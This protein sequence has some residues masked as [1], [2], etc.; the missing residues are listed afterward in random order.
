MGSKLFWVENIILIEKLKIL[1]LIDEVFF[2]DTRI[3][4]HTS[5]PRT[6]SSKANNRKPLLQC[7]CSCTA[8]SGVSF[9]DQEY[10]ST[11]T[12]VP[13]GVTD[14]A[15]LTTTTPMTP[16]THSSTTTVQH[17]VIPGIFI[18]HQPSS[19][20]G[21]ISQPSFRPA[22]WPRPVRTIFIKKIILDFKNFFIMI[23]LVTVSYFW[24][25]ISKFSNNFKITCWISCHFSLF[26]KK[27]YL[28]YKI[29]VFYL[30]KF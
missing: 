23:F 2:P 13:S 26:F 4:Y 1:L 8:A 7:P 16:T 25:S 15:A 10:R 22:L 28:F 29:F 3:F 9:D 12:S 24:P 14:G 5:T 20:D 6:R 21:S 17:P 19:A 11:V 30:I 18:S 27:I